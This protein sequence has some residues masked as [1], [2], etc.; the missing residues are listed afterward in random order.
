MEQYTLRTRVGSIPVIVHPTFWLLLLII[1]FLSAGRYPGRPELALLI[2]A[3]FGLSLLIHELGHCAA[4]KA[5]DQK[6]VAYLSMGGQTLGERPLPPTE[7]I[8]VSFAGPLTQIVLVGVP[9]LVLR[10]IVDLPQWLDIF[11]EGLGYFC[12]FWGIIN[13]LPALPLDGGNAAVAY[14]TLRHG[15]PRMR[16]IHQ[17]GVGVGIVGIIYS[18]VTGSIF[19]LFLWVMVIVLNFTALRDPYA[20]ARYGVGAPD[21]AYGGYANYDQPTPSER[22]RSKKRFRTEGSGKPAE[23]LAA[24]Y[25]LLERHDPRAARERV[26]PLMT[27]KNKKRDRSHASV[28]AAWSHLREGQPTPAAELLGAV[29]ESVP[30]LDLAREVTSVLRSEMDLEGLA[31]GLSGALATLDTRRDA[32]QALEILVRRDQAVALARAMLARSDL[33]G[34]LRVQQTLHDMGRRS[35]AQ[36]VSDLLLGG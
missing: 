9:C 32:R 4:Y 15:N 35:L 33:D 21:A 3:A 27:G 28:I 6:P 31:P 34:V 19:F 30:G 12:I 18:F 25:D 23:V 10:T 26:A 1:G 13:L 16:T 29:E 8:V 5:F 7:Q 24:G 14:S 11:T 22:K 17:I 2:A 36:E 20:A